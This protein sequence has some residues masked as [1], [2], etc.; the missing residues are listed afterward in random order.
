MVGYQR[1]SHVP[2]I[3][4]GAAL[5][6]EVL[7]VGGSGAVAQ[8]P[9][10]KAACGVALAE[11]MKEFGAHKVLT[12]H[13]MNCD[14]ADFASWAPDL[15]SMPPDLTAWALHGSPK[16]SMAERTATLQQFLDTPTPAIIAS[17]KALQEGVDLTGVDMV[18]GQHWVGREVLSRAVRM[19]GNRGATPLYL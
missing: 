2:P 11:A 15:D 6:D 5:G 16:M 3:V 14:A 17:V 7:R 13:T 19:E 12:F 18:R 9:A 1:A 8:V 4:C 10:H